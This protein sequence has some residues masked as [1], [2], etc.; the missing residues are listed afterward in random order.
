NIGILIMLL[1][2]AIW[3][4]AHTLTKPILE[5]KEI[6]SIQLVFIRN[7][8]N[9]I[10]LISTYFIFFPIQNIKLIFDP[11]SQIYFIIMGFAY[12]FDLFFWYKAISYINVSTA[13]IIIAPS[14]I[15]TALF[16][17]LFLGEEFTIFHFFGTIII[18][19]SILV[20]VKEKGK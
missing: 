19:I 18:I 6:T 5:R 17:T 3:M 10:I 13:T 20:I 16:A 9:S 4:I 1:T 12:S 8:L 15:I 7:L 14:P 11:L 2:A